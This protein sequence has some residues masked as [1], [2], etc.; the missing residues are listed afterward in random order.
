[1]GDQHEPSTIHTALFPVQTRTILD[2]RAQ[3]NRVRGG[4]IYL[5]NE[6]PETFEVYRQFLYFGIIYSNT[7]QTDQDPADDG[8]DEAY[9][10]SEWTRF[11]HLYTMG[12]DLDDEKF[13]NAVV[14]SLVEK[15]SETV[16]ILSSAFAFVCFRTDTCSRT[17]TRPASPPKSTATPPK[18]TS[19]VRW[20]LTSTSVKVSSFLYTFPLTASLILHR[21]RPRHRRP[22]AA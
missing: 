4:P 2:T 8:R 5:I 21:P 12:L 11:A 14:D 15:V 19:C 18:A 1:V 17:V 16:C 6:M 9:D 7:P 20:S 10:D 22:R 13:R 3:Q